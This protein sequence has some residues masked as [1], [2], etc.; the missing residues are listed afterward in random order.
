MTRKA[1]EYTHMKASSHIDF[2]IIILIAEL[3]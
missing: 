2:E 1:D 3:K